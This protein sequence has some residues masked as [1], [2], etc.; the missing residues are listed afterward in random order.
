MVNAIRQGDMIESVRVSGGDEL[1]GENAEQVRRWNEVLD[2][3]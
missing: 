3:A 1:L 2:A